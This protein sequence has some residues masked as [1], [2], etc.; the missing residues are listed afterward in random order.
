MKRKRGQ[1]TEPFTQ[2]QIILGARKIGKDS[3][4]MN[5][6]KLNTQMVNAEHYEKVA[7]EQLI[8]L[9]QIAKA[10]GLTYEILAE[11]TG[12]SRTNIGRSF[13]GKHIPRFDN[14]LKLY[15]VIVGDPLPSICDKPETEET[16]LAVKLIDPT[17]D[18]LSF[19]ECLEEDV[20]G[21][22]RA[23]ND[24]WYFRSLIEKA[25]NSYESQFEI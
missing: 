6:L 10:K 18:L 1:H 11:A 2:S 8:C 23:G 15:H 3:M 20:E 24:M 17:S 13:S 16:T 5:A 19:E 7:I 25:K 14:Y 12:I 9:R 22:E 4:F 21:G